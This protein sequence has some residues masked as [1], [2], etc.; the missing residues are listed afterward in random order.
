[1]NKKKECT[2]EFLLDFTAEDKIS[3]NIL[4]VNL[5]I[6]HIEIPKAPFI[7]ADVNQD[8]LCINQLGE[9]IF[10]TYKMMDD[11]IIAYQKH[12]LTK[13]LSKKDK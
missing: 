13:Q 1:M 6:R 4:S 7:E 3:D 10:V 11:L 5:K 8:M 9:N 2:C 12:K